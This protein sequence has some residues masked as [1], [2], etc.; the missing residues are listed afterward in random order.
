MKKTNPNA[1]RLMPAERPR[2]MQGTTVLWLS[3]VLLIP[4]ADYYFDA[5]DRR[6]NLVREEQEASRIELVEMEADVRELRTAELDWSRRAVRPGSVEAFQNR[7]IDLARKC[8]CRMRNASPGA[9]GRYEWVV[10]S[11]PFDRFGS[12]HRRSQAPVIDIGAQAM[13]L[14]VVGSYD[15]V[16]SF[17]KEVEA[18]PELVGVDTLRMSAGS[19]DGQIQLELELVL[20][21]LSGG[22]PSG[23]SRA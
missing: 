16:A 10:G 12:S 9:V 3:I 18:L 13:S 19:G 7:V 2:I 6:A 4:S 11:N 14:M 15:A 1:A 22:S 21:S 8:G 17:V 23:R 20:F 5:I